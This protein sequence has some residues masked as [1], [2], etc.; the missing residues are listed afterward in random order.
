MRR[1]HSGSAAR[2]PWR[3]AVGRRGPGP[4]TW[5]G[6]PTPWHGGV[7]AL[8]L[9]RGRARRPQPLARRRGGLGSCTAGSTLSA[10]PG[11]GCTRLRRRE[12]GGLSA[13]GVST[14]AAAL[15]RRRPLCAPQHRPGVGPTA[16]PRATRPREWRRRWKA[17]RAMSQAPQ[18]LDSPPFFGVIVEG[19]KRPT[20]EATLAGRP[21][22][23][24]E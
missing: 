7:V 4:R 19:N 20:G 21:D 9:G 16:A 3:G 10:R 12:L 6:R 18:S 14:G 8:A 24:S 5:R 1:P 2:Q 13:H 11:P 22:S 15:G 17:R 23:S